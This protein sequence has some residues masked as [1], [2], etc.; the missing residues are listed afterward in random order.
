[1]CKNMDFQKQAQLFKQILGLEYEPLAISFTNDEI[2]T[3]KYEKISICRALKLAA[4]GESF[5]IDE[6]VS[7]CPGGS[8]YCGFTKVMAH[9]QKR[10]LQKFLTQGEKLTGS[11]VS[12]ERMQKLTTEPPTELADRILITPLDKAEIRPDM[13]LFQCNPEQACRLITLDTYWNG[14]SPKQQLIGALC[15]TSISY[16]IMTGNTNVSLEIGQQE[17]IKN[18][19]IT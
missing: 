1:M 12:F 9:D 14:I 18:S 3:D 15:N 13:I 4:K 10:K 8:R 16:T 19:I 5:L 11:I 2:T 6:N 17:N 7:T